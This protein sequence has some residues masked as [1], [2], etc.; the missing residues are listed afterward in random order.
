M[1]VG[2]MIKVL[3][4]FPEDEDVEI[5]FPDDS[6]GEG[7]GASIDEIAYITGKKAVKSGV[8]LKIFQS[9]HPVWGATFIGVPFMPS[10]L[11]FLK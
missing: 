11:K 10:R 2:E 6:Y 8:Y 5:L 7:D 9:T 4:R 1:T 3:S